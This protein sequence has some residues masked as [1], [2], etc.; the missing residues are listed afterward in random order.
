MPTRAN[1]L[2]DLP[3]EKAAHTTNQHADTNCPASLRLRT[4]PS[5]R[6][7]KL[8]PELGSD[9]AD[10]TLTS[11]RLPEHLTQE[12]DHMAAE[13]RVTRSDLIR[14]AVEQYCT[15]S[16]RRGVLDRV[17]LLHRL[18]TYRGSGRGDLARRS[19]E[20]LRELFDARRRHRSD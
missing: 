20:R 15:A 4:R 2:L 12:L 9:N 8:L 5:A 16:Q 7:P 11:I 13:R 1:S 18:L 19:E 3:L 14:E 17:T 10:L 6:V